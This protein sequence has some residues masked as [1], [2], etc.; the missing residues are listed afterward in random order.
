M[1]YQENVWN[2]LMA[3]AKKGTEQ[4]SSSRVTNARSKLIDKLYKYYSRTS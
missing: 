1:S 3:E 4:A 2:A